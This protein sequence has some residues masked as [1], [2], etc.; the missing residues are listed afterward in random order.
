MQILE[1]YGVDGYQ[2]QHITDNLDLID[3][4]PKRMDKEIMKVVNK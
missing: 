3:Y 2:I 1:I 4:N